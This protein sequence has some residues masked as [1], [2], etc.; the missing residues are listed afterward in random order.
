LTLRKELIKVRGW[1]VSPAELEAVLIKHSGLADAAVIGVSSLDR[2]AE[3]PRAYVVRKVDCFVTEHDI[4]SFLLTYLARYKVGDCQIRFIESIPRNP[5]GKILKKALRA[6][7]DNE[8]LESLSRSN[9][10][11]SDG[12]EDVPDSLPRLGVRPLVK[13]VGIPLLVIVWFGFGQRLLTGGL[14]GDS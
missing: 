12:L 7:V 9:K 6:E 13:A 3:V 1:Q 11:S 4:K 8:A 10:E 14:L 5:S 2:T